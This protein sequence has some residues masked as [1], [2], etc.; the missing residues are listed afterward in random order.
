MIKGYTKEL[1]DLWNKKYAKCLE[2]GVVIKTDNQIIY[3]EFG[4]GSN[5]DDDDIEEGF[6]DYINLTI[7]EDPDND[8]TLPEGNLDEIKEYLDGELE[9]YDGG[10]YMFSTKEGFVSYYEDLSDFI[11]YV[12]SCV[13]NIDITQNPVLLYAGI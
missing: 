10:M 2:K 11:E 4:D 13:E 5:L 12:L 1:A 3:A 8:T 7:Y 9:E 6:D